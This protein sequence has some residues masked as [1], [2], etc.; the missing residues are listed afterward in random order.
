[1][2]TPR[3]LALASMFSNIVTVGIRIYKKK[4]VQH[5][6]ISKAASSEMSSQLKTGKVTVPVSD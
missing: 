4:K 1:M 6:R 3:S 2:S 5:V